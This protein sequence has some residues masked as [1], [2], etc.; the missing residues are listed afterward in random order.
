MADHFFITGWIKRE[1]YT[2]PPAMA[3]T[4]LPSRN[5]GGHGAKLKSQFE[6]AWASA[7]EKQRNVAVI[8]GT[9]EG[10]LIQFE[11]EPTF[12]IELGKLDLRSQGIELRTVKQVG[13]VQ[14][15][16][17]FVPS[18]KVQTFINKFEQYLTQETKTGK[19]KNQPLVDSISD[20]RL[21]TIE[22]LWTENAPFPA[23]SDRIWWE[24][25]L[26]TDGE[27]EIARFQ[28]LVRRLNLRA[29]K[30]HLS[31]PDR[32]VVLA[33]ASP[34]ELSQ[35]LELLNDF[36][37]LR[38]S[39]DTPTF[40]VRLHQTEQAE[41]ANDL[42]KRTMPAEDNAPAICILDTGV[43]RGHPLL[44]ASLGV[45]HQF[46]YLSAWG[47]NDLQGHGTEMAGVALYGNVTQALASRSNVVLTHQLESAKILPPTGENPP[48]LYGVIT[49]D[50]TA[51]AEIAAPNRE[52]LY[53]LAIS[54]PDQ[55]DRGIP[56]SWSAEIDALA[57][58][59]EEPTDSARR[60]FIVAAGN[61]TAALSPD[62]FSGSLTDSIHDPGQSWNALTVGA[63][64][65]LVQ[66][67]EPTHSGWQ[68]L[69]SNRQ[70]SPSSTTSVTWQT[71]WPLK[72]EI[73]MEGGNRAISPD[74][75][76]IDTLDSLSLL[77]TN[78]QMQQRLFT[79]TGDTSAAAAQAA[80]MAAIVQAR[81]PNARPETI[82]AILIHS[83]R[84]SP[85]MTTQ[86]GGSGRQA[87]EN[88]LRCFGYGA[89]DETR[90]LESTSNRLVLIAEEKIYP[91][92]RDRTKEMLLHT[93]PW[94]QDVLEE[95][96]DTEVSL[97]VTLSYFIEPNPAQRGWKQ[98]HRYASHGLRF[99]VKT[100]TESL[101]QFRGRLNQQAREEEEGA[102]SS[103]DAGRWQLGP[104]LRSK[105]SIHSDVWTG[106]AAELA[107]RGYVGIYPVIGW[108]RERHQLNRWQNG[109]RYS[110]LVSIETAAVDVDLYIPVSTIIDTAI[111]IEIENDL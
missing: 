46:A 44:E 86:A 74:H 24:I 49:A 55:R 18:G 1:S 75:T 80:R 83:A 17:V 60:L 111:P 71:Q 72:P 67:D 99:D 52:R 64:T 96:G 87:T 58:N 63:Y 33:Y 20:V 69:A 25:W 93:L 73:V 107:E 30:Q 47:L 57:A 89:P 12:Q 77:T 103:S 100:P 81:Y 79:T 34:A 8:P 68:P 45:S 15:A 37:E 48:E 50:A 43:N 78:H 109:A 11:S 21:A 5:R 31:F 108:W 106:T 85:E 19:P 84:W 53:L 62:Y 91:F 56:T 41:W 90:A 104:K 28:E 6:Q 82:R 59:S 40:F 2:A 51:Q 101:D 29:G 23:T 39:K 9:P 88:L 38:M 32:T 70:L 105:G 13:D 14:I 22:S 110:L 92:E 36:A 42:K 66:I 3:R 16:T 4:R 7:E 61:R 98:K 65:E 10:F 35:S 76:Q 97:R 27:L 54:A 95:L 26:R 102:T 94:P